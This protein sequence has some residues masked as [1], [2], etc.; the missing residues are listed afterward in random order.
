MP[1]RLLVLLAAGLAVAAPDGGAS[2]GLPRGGTAQ[3]P[4]PRIVAVGDVHGAFEPFVAILQA[5]GLIDAQRKWVGGTAILVQTGDVF[6]RGAG[7]RDAFD[8]LMRLEGE[9]R[10]AGGR[11]ESLLGNHEMMNMLSELR[12]A[13]PDAYA[14]FADG[15]SEGRRKRAYEE[16][17]RIAARRGKIGPPALSQDEWMKS[18][19]PGF[20]EYVDAFGPRGKYGRWLR[21][22]KVVTTLNGTVFMHAGVQA[23]RAAP[24]DEIN[25]TAE[26]EIA[27]WDDTRAMMVQA[28][29][30]PPFC[31]LADAGEAA[32]A[33]IER[34]NE[35][36]KNNA[37]L[38]DHVT[39]EFVD[40]LQSLFQIGKSSLLDPEGPL[41]FRGFAQW[42]DTEEPGVAALA[43][44]LGVKRFV[45][46]H[47]PSLPGRIR[48]RFGN[49]IFVIDTGMLSTYY[50]TGRASALEL[51]NDRITAIYTDA[52]EVLVPSPSASALPG[53]FRGG[54]AATAA[55]AASR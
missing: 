10:R 54:R 6:D 38:G 26:R 45:T 25:R 13:S 31:T 3:A 20:V 47:T 40:R 1:P 23:D 8:L 14:A 35:A 24:L 18:H 22:R 51:Q 37:P 19:P 12:D 15:R 9:A 34:I 11:V 46:G 50:K 7:V 41:W 49:R 33:E 27:G 44:R 53:F 36:I 28:Q 39:R 42:P 55:S 43:E 30:V 5:A 29:L 16:Y 4:P 32:A 48:G 21:S 2:A 17:A 52:R